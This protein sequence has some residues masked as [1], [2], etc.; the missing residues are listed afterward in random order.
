MSWFPH[1]SSGTSPRIVISSAINGASA[2]SAVDVDQDGDV[3]VV[4]V[5]SYGYFMAWFENQVRSPTT[6]SAA[7]RTLPPANVFGA[8]MYTIATDIPH[9]LSMAVADIEGD[10]K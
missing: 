4:V 3:D 2:A 10:G 5:S 6:P 7:A 8:V 1:A 9:V